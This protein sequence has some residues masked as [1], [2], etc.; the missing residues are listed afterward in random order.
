MDDEASATSGAEPQ[1]LQQLGS[2]IGQSSAQI[3]P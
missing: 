2:S 1:A 3:Y